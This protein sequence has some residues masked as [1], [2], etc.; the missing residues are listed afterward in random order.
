M[1]PFQ[2]FCSTLA[3]TTPYT[4][5]RGRMFLV[6]CCIDLTHREPSK[7]TTSFI[8]VFIFS[9]NSTPGSGR[10]HPPTRS[11]LA[12]SPLQ[13]PL[14]RRHQLSFD[15]CVTLLNGGHHSG[16]APFLSLFFCSQLAAPNEGQPSSPHVPPRSRALPTTPSN[17]EADFWLV[18]AFR[19]AAT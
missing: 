14:Q 18:V 10:Q 4:L 16:G 19:L 11:I 13:R 8:F 9:F 5:R 2:Y 3:C 17:I 7:A 15:C 6:G 12:A 1:L